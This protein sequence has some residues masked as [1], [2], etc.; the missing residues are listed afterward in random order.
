[1]SSSFLVRKWKETQVNHRNQFWGV[2]GVRGRNSEAVEPRPAASAGQAYSQKSFLF[3]SRTGI[4]KKHCIS[5]QS[6]FY[7]LSYDFLKIYTINLASP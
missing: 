2:G 5:L 7:L 3:F 1:M 6:I 4:C